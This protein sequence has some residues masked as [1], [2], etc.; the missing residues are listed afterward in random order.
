MANPSSKVQ[1][2]YQKVRSQLDVRGCVW[3]AI[4]MF[5]DTVMNILR[6]VDPEGVSRRKGKRLKRRSYHS[7]VSYT[8]CC[9]RDDVLPI[10]SKLY[11]AL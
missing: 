2:D 9:S 5:R 6:Q 1:S 8:V 3:I 4:V 7:K 10:G 11:M